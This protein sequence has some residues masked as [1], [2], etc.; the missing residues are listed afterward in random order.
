MCT[1]CHTLSPPTRCE[2]HSPQAVQGTQDRLE[3]PKQGLGFLLKQYC[4][5]FQN[6]LGSSAEATFFLDKIT[7]GTPRGVLSTISN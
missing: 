7:L 1:Q 6:I 2:A 5:E 4:L 3:A